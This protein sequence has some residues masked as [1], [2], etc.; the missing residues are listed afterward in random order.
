MQFPPTFTF[1]FECVVAR[2]CMRTK[3]GQVLSGQQLQPISICVISCT[4]S[5]PTVFH[6]CDSYFPPTSPSS[7]RSLLLRVQ[8]ASFPSKFKILLRKSGTRL[9]KIIGF[10]SSIV[11][12]TKIS[13]SLLPLFPHSLRNSVVSPQTDF[14]S[15]NV[16]KVNDSTLFKNERTLFRH[17]HIK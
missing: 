15:W 10:S 8:T 11:F 14:L 16:K 9:S 7:I 1:P 13:E 3:W 6:S 4:A 5:T 17:V 12:P 2:Q